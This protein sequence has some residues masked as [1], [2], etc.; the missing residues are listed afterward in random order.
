MSRRQQEDGTDAFL[1]WVLDGAPGPAVAQV[2][3]ELPPPV[4]TLLLEQWT[5]AHASRVA[6]L[7]G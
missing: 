6:A 1:P 7:P 4:R 3:N 5:P 2:T